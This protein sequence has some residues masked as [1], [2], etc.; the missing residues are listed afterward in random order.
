M[1]HAGKAVPHPDKGGPHVPL[2]L[3]PAMRSRATVSTLSRL[4]DLLL[5]VERERA[6]GAWS[7]WDGAVLDAW[8]ETV[9]EKIRDCEMDLRAQ[10]E[11]AGA[12]DACGFVY[13]AAD[14]EIVYPDAPNA[15]RPAL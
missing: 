11:A 12:Y 15:Q 10:L 3:L 2:A 14:Y 8:R 5:Y 13:R 7:D 1:N 9:K 4:T 6:A